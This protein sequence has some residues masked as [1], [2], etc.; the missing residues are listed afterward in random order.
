MIDPPSKKKVLL[1]APGVESSFREKAC[2]IVGFFF[3]LFTAVAMESGSVD[4]CLPVLLA[5][6]SQRWS[7]ETHECHRRSLQ[8]E[9][10]QRTALAA[11]IRRFQT[12]VE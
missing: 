2:R 9:G 3:F 6:S 8:N 4:L 10:K 5:C 12:C 11:V 7:E 1:Q